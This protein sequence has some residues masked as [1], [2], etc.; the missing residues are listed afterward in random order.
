[1]TTGVSKKAALKKALTIALISSL[2]LALLPTN[3]SAVTKITPGASCK[4]LNQ[5]VTYQNKIFTC[6]KLNNSGKKLIWNKGV[7]VKKQSPKASP[8]AP[9]S[10]TPTPTAASTSTQTPSK[11]AT[12]AASISGYTLAQVRANNSRQSCWSIIDNYVYDL[13]SW[14]NSHPGGASAIL[15]LCGADGTSAFNSQHEN[16]SKPAVRLETYRLGPLSK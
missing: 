8:P 15:S 11:S 3:S 10:P 12:P 16:Q 7:Q 1:M 14:I 5:K 4:V 9:I 2:F 13:T 6:I